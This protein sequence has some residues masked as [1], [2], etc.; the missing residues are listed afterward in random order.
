[1]RLSVV[2]LKKRLILYARS[3]LN[4][5]RINRSSVMDEV[6]KIES[7]V[8]EIEIELLSFVSTHKIAEVSVVFPCRGPLI[9]F[10]EE[11]VSVHNEKN[12]SGRFLFSKE[13][14]IF[15]TNYFFIENNNTTNAK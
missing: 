9:I 14:K 6:N 12:N 8:L 11:I 13:F 5:E 15:I 4:D 2:F 3:R 7:Q 1:M 10:C